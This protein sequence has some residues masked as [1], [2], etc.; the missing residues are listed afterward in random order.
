MCVCSF[1]KPNITQCRVQNSP[2]PMLCWHPAE[3]Q[4]GWSREHEVR[5][6]RVHWP[7]AWE[8]TPCWW[9]TTWFGHVWTSK[10]NVQCLWDFLLSSVPT[11]WNNDSKCLRVHI[12]RGEARKHAMQQSQRPGMPWLYT[13]LQCSSFR[14]H[15]PELMNP[16]EYWE[17]IPQEYPTISNIT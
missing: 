14:Y 7:K 3:E 9:G 17:L 5:S 4:E 15:G 13:E 11:S 10:S 16:E 12:F 6:P 8:A 1:Q 2:T